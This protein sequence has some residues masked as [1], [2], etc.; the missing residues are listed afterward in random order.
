MTVRTG[1]K[2]ESVFLFDVP[3]KQERP[4]LNTWEKGMLGAPCICLSAFTHVYCVYVCMC[5]YICI[6][7]GRILGVLELSNGT[8]IN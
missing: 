2:N 8:R 5:I 1:T 3:G 4:N 7:A 6:H